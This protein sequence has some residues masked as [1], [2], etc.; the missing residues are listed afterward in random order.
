M[1]SLVLA[2]LVATAPGCAQSGSPSEPGA[3][4]PSG[5]A[6]SATGA[7]SSPGALAPVQ[8]VR[9]AIDWQAAQAH[10]QL[11]A[12]LSAAQ[13][14]TLRRATLPVLL[15]VDGPWLAHGIATAAADWYT[16]SAP[17]GDL[18]VVIQGDRM[19]T[20]DP[21]LVPPRWT[22]PAWQTP[23]VTRN[24]GIVEATFLAFGASYVVAVECAMPD[25]DA[26]CTQDEFVLALIAAMRRWAPTGEVTP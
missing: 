9:K 8:R 10:P 1:R 18:T 13:A 12:A 20:L 3:A 25:S 16:L 22:P 17:V 23:L 7:L 15:P 11:D 24:E 21:T 6:A 5:P 4:A 14:Q 2:L 19:A 26:R